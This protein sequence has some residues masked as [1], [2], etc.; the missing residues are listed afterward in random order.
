[1]VPPIPAKLKV[2]RFGV[3]DFYTLLETTD[4]EYP[5]LPMEWWVPE[6][7]FKEESITGFYYEN[8]WN[9]E[10]NTRYY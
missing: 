5:S 7:Y 10:N 9:R 6:D 4:I 8:Y 3:D 2:D 1:M